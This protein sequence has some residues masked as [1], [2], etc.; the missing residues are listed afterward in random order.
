MKTT[1]L[2]FWPL[3]LSVCQL[4]AQQAGSYEAVVVGAMRDAMWKGQVYG[5]I[6]LDTITGRQ[7]LYGL[8]PVEYLA[9][10]LMIMDGQCY[11]STVVTDS[12]MRV[13]E[14]QQ[15]KAPFFAYTHIDNWT[16]HDLP[17][18]IRDIAQFETYLDSLTKN[19]KRPFMFRLSG[20]VEAAAIHIV[21]MPKGTVVRSPNDAHKGKTDYRLA[22]EQ[23]DIVGFFSTAHQTIFTHHDTFLH[24]HLITADRQKMGHLDEV[25][26]RPG[27]VKLY[28]PA[29]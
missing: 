7:H 4:R 15:V 12:T 3:L 9:G 18:G 25:L 11:R 16:A 6:S 10:E 17:G 14:V 5:R 23:S 13:E 28:L 19:L 29:E 26:F 2:V 21:N 20:M 8:G 22:D 24:M 27:A 1:L